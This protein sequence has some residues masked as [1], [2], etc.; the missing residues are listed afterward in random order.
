[1]NVRLKGNVS[2]LVLF[3]ML[4]SVV[5]GMT[6]KRVDDSSAN[7]ARKLVSGLPRHN[8]GQVRKQTKIARNLTG[9]MKTED[10]G[11]LEA[12]INNE[13]ENFDEDTLEGE[14]DDEE[15]SDEEGDNPDKGNNFDEDTLEGE[16]A[17]GEELN[18]EGANP[19]EENGEGKMR[20]KKSSE[21]SH[22]EHEGSE[23][24]SEEEA[25]RRP[26][27]PQAAEEWEYQR[28]KDSV[29]LL[30]YKMIEINE[31]IKEC[32]E[33][34][35]SED[36]M[37]DKETIMVQCVGIT[38]QILFQNYKEGMRK[39]KQIFIGMLKTKVKSLDEE[40]DDEI[41]FFFDILE[42]FVDKD[43]RLRESLEISKEAAKFYVSP[44]YYNDLLALAEPEI[45][46]FD[47]IHNKMRNNK[48]DVKQLI[49]EKSEE[50]EKYL[51]SLKGE[52]EHIEE[53]VD[54]D[55]EN[56]DDENELDEEE[57]QGGE[58]GDS[59]FNEEGEEEGGEEEGDE[60]GEG[61]EDE[62]GEEEGEEE[63]EEE[64]E[65]KKLKKK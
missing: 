33:Q 27:D 14:Q 10:L 63:E 49:I 24:D 4:C 16:Q 51:N 22:L 65:T 9:N 13:E 1:M 19:D 56:Q 43:F 26:L 59:E 31:L 39:I 23:V 17:D 20:K 61:E 40:Y 37:A 34:V 12:E 29:A 45:E 35:F 60:E 7:T 50:R 6:Y 30:E 2:L 52:A 3:I 55:E 25:N 36:L 32:V 47:F 8:I 62:Y 5:E 44:S 38:Y 58:E 18:E 42:D 64:G 53:Q 48:H 11:D 46:A 41:N 54:E 15:E 57:G 28:I 21:F